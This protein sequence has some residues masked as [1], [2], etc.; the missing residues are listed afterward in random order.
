M[1]RALGRNRRVVLVFHEDPQQ[2]VTL[3]AP[4]MLEPLTHTHR[5]FSKLQDFQ[6][7]RCRIASEMRAVG[8]LLEM[9]C[10][11]AFGT[12]PDQSFVCHDAVQPGGQACLS[13]KV[14]HVAQGLFKRGLDDVFGGGSISRET[15]RGAHEA[16][17]KLLVKHA[18]AERG[19]AR[20]LG[21]SQPGRLAL[22]R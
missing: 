19:G 20:A 5:A 7:L 3:G 18:K 12:Q 10:A 4:E 13:T 8:V 16:R 14:R 6:R 11:S 17:S 1:C 15:L 9:T 22:F 21:T 2:D